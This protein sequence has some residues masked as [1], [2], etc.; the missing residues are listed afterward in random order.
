MKN[1]EIDCN[2]NYLGPS[3]P[4]LSVK[5]V[6]ELNLQHNER[7]IVFQVDD[8]WTGTVLFDGNLPAMYQWYVLLD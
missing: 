2:F 1:I 3:Q 4:A 7:V 5:E 8:E 6:N